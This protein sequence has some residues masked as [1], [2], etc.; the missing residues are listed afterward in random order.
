MAKVT[1]ILALLT[2]VALVAALPM[3]VLAQ[4]DAPHV[5]IGT[6]I[7]NGLTAT[8]GVP[9]TA[10]DGDTQIGSTT[11][12][13]GGKFNLSVNRSSGRITFKIDNVNAAQSHPAWEF[14]GLETGF[15]L[16]ATSQPVTAGAAGPA[17]PAGAA[18]PAGRR[19][20]GARG[21]QGPAG[22]TGAAGAA[23]PDGARGP[24]GPQGEVGPAG[25]G[26]PAGAVG[27]PG[28]DGAPGEAGRAGTAG[29]TASS[30]LAIVAIIIAIVAVIAAVALPMVMRR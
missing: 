25:P 28:A 2:I 29:A 4:N 30:G 22:A 12:V 1:R 14:G 20:A 21:A 10:W 13:A 24:I 6:A 17:G 8:T 15:N 16:T 3:S 23:G 9:I 7:V 27:A 5:F 11:V 19:T 26:G 18:G